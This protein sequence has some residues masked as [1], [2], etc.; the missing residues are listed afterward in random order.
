VYNS[1]HEKSYDRFPLC[2]ETLALTLPYCHVDCHC[3][4]QCTSHYQNQFDN[5]KTGIQVSLVT[6]KSKEIRH[7]PYLYFDH[8]RS[9]DEHA[10]RQFNRLDSTYVNQRNM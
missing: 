10:A 3:N 5:S 8:H 6:C 4:K 1:L 9:M 2:I 7:N